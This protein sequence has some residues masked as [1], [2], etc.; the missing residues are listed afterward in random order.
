MVAQG[1]GRRPWGWV[2]N[3]VLPGLFFG[4]AY[5]LMPVDQ[6]FQFDTDEGIELV[7]ASLYAQGFEFYREIWSDHPPLFSIL[8]VQW[9]AWWGASVAA[10]RLLTLSFATLLIW[11]FAQTLRCFV[12]EA[13]ALL[14]ALLL[15]N[16]I[17][18]LRLSVSVMIGLPSLALAML[19]VY[20]TVKYSQSPRRS[21]GWLLLS[22]IA[23]ATSLQIKVFTGFLLPILLGMIGLA[24]GSSPQGGRWAIAQR[25]MIAPGLWLLALGATFGGLSLGMGFD[26]AAELAQFQFQGDLKAVFV[27]E[28]SLVDVLLMYLQDLDYGLLAVFGVMA[29]RP[30]GAIALPSGWRSRLPLL[31]LGLATGLMLT[32][33]PLWYHHYLV[34]AIPLTWLATLGLQAAVDQLQESG[35]A[36]PR[37]AA[38]RSAGD[39][40]AR[41][42]PRAVGATVLLSFV[43]LAA[44]VKLA[45]TQLQNRAV[46]AAGAEHQAV[47]A[48]ILNYQAETHW[49]FTDLPMYAIATGL[50]LPPPIAAISRKRVAAGEISL[51]F[52][53]NIIAQY[54]PEQFVL[55]RFPEIQEP[56]KPYLSAHYRALPERAG[57]QH[58]VR[59]DLDRF[60]P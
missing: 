25:R 36:W 33:K 60:T 54:Q 32:H 23:L 22:A 28:N 53:E 8:L 52:L 27:R 6:A 12:Q 56:L 35:P 55:A 41:S 45:A 11:A 39:P 31:W 43:L 48:A 29:G 38:Q 14:G 5:L 26:R 58:W 46:L 50:N 51:P 2:F 7:R 21:W 19:A 44:P 3:L 37:L 47:V 59:R 18:F 30:A 10:A 4:L 34:L 1:L 24:A 17:N 49:L 15:A 20:A 13:I 16:S 57:T 40:E 9:Q 42:R